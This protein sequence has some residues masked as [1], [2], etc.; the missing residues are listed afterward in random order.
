[1]L[2]SYLT[3]IIHVCEQRTELQRHT[4]VAT[5]ETIRQLVLPQQPSRLHLLLQELAGREIL[6]L[7][8]TYTVEPRLVVER[9]MVG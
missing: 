6:V 8:I 7:K 4:F 2:V 3:P 9:Y 5:S 1:M